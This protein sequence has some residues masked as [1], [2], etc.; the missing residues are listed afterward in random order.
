MKKSELRQI[1]REEILKL[2]ENSTNE[3]TSK[4]LNSPE[5]IQQA[6]LKKEIERRGLKTE[7]EIELSDPELAVRW[8]RRK[9]NEEKQE[10][11]NKYL[12]DF[13][14]DDMNH[15]DIYWL[16]KKQQKL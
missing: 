16:W 13:K 4:K 8:W 5:S 11:L 2:S 6:L 15:Q 7:N 9:N 3:I 1:I 14:I 10:L 12:P